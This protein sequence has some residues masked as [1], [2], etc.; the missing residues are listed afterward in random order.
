MGNEDPADI[1]TR[2]D[3]ICNYLRA[4]LRDVAQLLVGKCSLR[5]TPDSRYNAIRRDEDTILSKKK[6]SLAI[7]S[8]DHEE[9]GRANGAISILLPGI[10]HFTVRSHDLMW[11]Y[12][13]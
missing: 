2:R 5:C 11:I 9:I 8:L 1:I 6:C 4:G 3:M 13:Y 12:Y 10:M 7:G